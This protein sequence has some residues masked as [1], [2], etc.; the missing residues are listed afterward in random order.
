V[1]FDLDAAIRRIPDYPQ[2]GVLFFDIMPLFE[3]PDALDHCVRRL[4]QHA[5]GVSSD[6]VLGIEARGLILGGAIARDIGTGLAV[7][8][9][10]GKLPA[11]TLARDYDLEYGT[12]R[13]ELHVGAIAPGARVFVHDDLLATG[14]TA[15]A[16]C[17][18]VEDSGGIVA[19]VAFIVELSFLPGRTRLEALGYDVRSLVTFDSEE[20]R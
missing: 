12:D 11:Q 13:L 8:R 7:A 19:A 14:G 16:A 2:P 1:S 9:K 5:R 6:A 20:M 15:E 3:R 4:A 18:L 17:R 10:P